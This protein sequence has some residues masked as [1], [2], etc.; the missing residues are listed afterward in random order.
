[1]QTLG[2]DKIQTAPSP[3]QTGYRR[4]PN[5]CR[6]WWTVVWARRCPIRTLRALPRCAMQRTSAQ[7]RRPLRTS[8]LD[9]SRRT[10]QGTLEPATC[11]SYPIQQGRHQT[12]RPHQCKYRWPQYCAQTGA[13]C[14]KPRVQKCSPIQ[15]ACQSRPLCLPRSAGEC[16]MLRLWRACP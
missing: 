2:Q 14:R 9:P 15:A 7:S 4:R 6:W 8:A 16:S 3:C 10:G 11:R 12:S 1:M 5:V 13:T